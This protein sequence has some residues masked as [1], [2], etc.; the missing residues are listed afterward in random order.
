MCDILPH[1]ICSI[2]EL[3]PSI[4]HYF[5]QHFRELKP[6]MSHAIYK[7]LG[8]E[9]IHVACY[10]HHFEVGTLMLHITCS[11]LV[12]ELPFLAENLQHVGFE[13]LKFAR[14]LQAVVGCWLL[15]V[16]CWLLVVGC[17]LWVAG[18]G[19]WVLF[20]VVALVAIVVAIAIVIVIVIVIVVFVV[21]VIVGLGFRIFGSRDI[22]SVLFP[23]LGSSFPLGVFRFCEAGSVT[24]L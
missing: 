17:G 5:L 22:V 6:S 12:L 16:G 7:I 14:Y 10:L 24:F 20:V 23:G 8:S 4:G 18:C 1:G 19:L 15:L 13:F 2:L 3:D 21:V 11:M 9:P